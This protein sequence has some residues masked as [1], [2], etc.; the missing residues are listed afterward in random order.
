MPITIQAAHAFEKHE[1]KVCNAVDVKHI[2]E[3]DIDCSFFHFQLQ[4][5]TFDFNSD[6]EALIL[7]YPTEILDKYIASNYRIYLISNSSRA[8][9]FFIVS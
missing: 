2:H 7:Q 4:Q 6:Y 3:H 1:H 9:P 8:P 5:D